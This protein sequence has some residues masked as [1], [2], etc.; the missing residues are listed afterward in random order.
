MVF[1]RCD[2]TLFAA[3]YH[4]LQYNCLFVIALGGG[5]M[6]ILSVTLK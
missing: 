2:A 6:G 5:E 4:A 3:R 1:T